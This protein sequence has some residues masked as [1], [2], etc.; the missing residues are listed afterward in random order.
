MHNCSSLSCT[1]GQLKTLKGRHKEMGCD[2]WQW[3]KKKWEKGSNLYKRAFNCSFHVVA[4]LRMH[5]I[6]MVVDVVRQPFSGH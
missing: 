1:A 6:I 4:R 5:V 3:Q 2:M